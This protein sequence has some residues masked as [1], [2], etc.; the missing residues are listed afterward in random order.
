MKAYKALVKFALANSMTVSVWD[1]EEWQLKR[2]TG[3]QAIV[4]AINSVEVAELR[5]RDS[6]GNVTGWAQIIPDLEDDE[7]LADYTMT[8]FMERF[9]DSMT[10]QQYQSNDGR[11]DFARCAE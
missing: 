6:E 2:S 5:I 10:K 11:E 1:G 3:Y 9:E 4:D 7:T 8:P